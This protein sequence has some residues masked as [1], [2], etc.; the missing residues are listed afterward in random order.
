MIWIRENLGSIILLIFIVGLISAITVA[1]IRAKK[2]GKSSCGCGCEHCAM[3]DK[4]H[5]NK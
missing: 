2:K 3:K 4:C 1:S 5:Q